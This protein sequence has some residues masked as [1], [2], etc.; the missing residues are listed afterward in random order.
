M[1]IFLKT[2]PKSLFLFSLYLSN[3]AGYRKRKENI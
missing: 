3:V 2:I 1:D